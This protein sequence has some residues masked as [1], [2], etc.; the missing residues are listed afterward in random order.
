MREPLK[1]PAGR[2]PGWRDRLLAYHRRRG[3]RGFT[4]LLDLLK[5]PGGRR[6]IR[7]VTRYGTQFLLVPWDVVDSHTIAE[8]FYESE[9]IEA[10]RP[11]L[12]P[13]S[14]VWFIGANFGLH[15][16][17]AKV[18]EPACRI[19]CFEPN[20]RMG[21]RIMENAELN[22]VAVELYA[23][24]L[25]DRTGS[26]T[27]FANAS[28]NPGMSTLHPVAGGA[29][30]DRYTVAVD[31]AARLLAQ[32][33]APFPRAVVLDVEGAELEVLRGFGDALADPR[34]ECLVFEAENGL[35]EAGP[36]PALPELLG[37]AG[38]NHIERLTRR[39]HTAHALSNFLAQR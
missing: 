18:L 23:L 39:E 20:P 34:L 14:V 27:F 6:E 35:L 15:A 29:Y 38:F 22:A 9:V 12:Q 28:G 16:I 21:A 13:G 2:P 36:G 24:A 4:R 32:G 26:A 30:D 19:V 33:G 17:T 1:P 31:T 37:G 7:F 5:P 10:V 8:G 11:A 25:A 3:W